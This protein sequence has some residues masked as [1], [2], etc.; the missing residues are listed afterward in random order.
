MPIHGAYY[1]HLGVS[2]SARQAFYDRLRSVAAQHQAPMA[3]FEQ[4]DGDRFFLR[5]PHSHP[6]E[7]GWVHINKVLDDFYHDRFPR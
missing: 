4:F 2:R 5:D 7:K 1:D 3:E 6:S